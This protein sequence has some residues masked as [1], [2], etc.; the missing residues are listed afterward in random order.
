MLVGRKWPQDFSSQVSL[1]EHH[2]RAFGGLPGCHTSPS[3]TQGKGLESVIHFY[4]GLAP[5][6]PMAAATSPNHFLSN[7]RCPSQQTESSSAQGTSG[8][9]LL[10]TNQLKLGQ[11]DEAVHATSSEV[12]SISKDGGFTICLSKQFHCLT[13]LSLKKCCLLL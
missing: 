2:P 12:P 11:L 9:H 10:Q 7:T 3:L 1:Q 13:T 5:M 6:I 4:P 8:D